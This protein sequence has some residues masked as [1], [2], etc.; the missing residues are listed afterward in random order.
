MQIRDSLRCT[1]KEDIAYRRG[2]IWS[3]Y[4]LV[5][6]HHLGQQHLLHIP[7]RGNQHHH[8]SGGRWECPYPGHKRYCSSW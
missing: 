8:S 3:L 1:G 5:A 4:S 2:L 6:S 7:V